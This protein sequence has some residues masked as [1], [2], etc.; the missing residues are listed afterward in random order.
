[1]SMVRRLIEKFS[2][3][4]LYTMSM[5]TMVVLVVVLTGCSGGGGGGASMPGSDGDTM[6]PPPGQEQIRRELVVNKIN[7][8]QDIEHSNA[9]NDDVVLDI[10]NA[11]ANIP[12][13]RGTTPQGQRVVSSTSQN[14]A[15]SG[16]STNT[17]GLIV[18][19]HDA[20]GML[21]FT[22]LVEGNVTLNTNDQGASITRLEGTPEAGWKGVVF[23]GEAGMWNY[24][25]DF[26]SDIENN[27]D[28][29]YLV[30]GYWLSAA[31]ERSMTSSNYGLLIAAG[32]NNP[33][34]RSNLDGLTSKA[35][36]EGPATGLYMSKANISAVPEFDYFTAKASLT[37]DFGDSNTLGSV[38]GTITEGTT[39]GGITLPELN[40]ESAS[41]FNTAG[42]GNFRDNTSGVTD[43]GVTFSGK[44]G[45]K[46]FGDGASPT[47]HPG[48]VAGTFGANSGDDLQSILG[49]FGAYKQ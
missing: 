16:G 9:S 1:M 30:M 21:H 15:P 20:D 7:E 46:F 12:R 42:G 43:G 31:K 44:W 28:N 25:G 45:G 22:L 17:R 47:D 8:I 27:G 11:A 13:G 4:F 36:Y 49:V 19:E 33:F 39:A 10:L 18:A 32:G 26:F 48:S 14:S 29:D 41:I 35:T 5:L 23:Q 6:T 2:R 34:E 3:P 24:Y 40:L 37:A 38:S